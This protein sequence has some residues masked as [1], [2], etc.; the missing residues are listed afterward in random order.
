M[1]TT[2]RGPNVT[3]EEAMAA[4]ASIAPTLEIIEQRPPPGKGS[5]LLSGVDNG[6]QRAFVVGA[7]T[8]YDPSI[9][10]LS[11]ASVDLYVDGE[12]QE[13][14]YGVEIMESSPIASI[15]WLAAKLSAF[16]LELKAGSAVMTG[17]FTKQYRFEGPVDVEA[18][19]EPFGT[20]TAKFT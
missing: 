15:I 18:R 13:K 19:F 14:A 6:Q 1:G 8:A 20:V 10:D 16:D 11:K 17:S 9:H 4:V 12:F 5:G 7:E 2:L 3:G